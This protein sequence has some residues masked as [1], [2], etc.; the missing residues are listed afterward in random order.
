MDASEAQTATPY[1]KVKH[2]TTEPM[3]CSIRGVQGLI[4]GY[5]YF[6][7]TKHLCDLI[8]IST[9]GEVGNEKLLKDYSDFLLLTVSRLCLFCWSELLF[10]FHVVCENT[11]DILCPCFSHAT[12]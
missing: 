2:S 3:C 7:R 10:V 8:H 4:H 1:S 5:S 9:K 6:M 12:I 11:Q